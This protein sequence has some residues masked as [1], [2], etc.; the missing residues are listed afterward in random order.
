MVQQY[1][2][3]ALMLEQLRNERYRQAAQGMQQGLN[4]A[5]QTYMNMEQLKQA[6]AE[7]KAERDERARQFN[8]MQKYRD[9][10]LQSLQ[11]LRAGQLGVQQQQ[12]AL[13]EKK[14]GEAR[15]DVLRQQ[16][17]DD[18]KQMALGVE[19]GQKP[20]TGVDT[21]TAKEFMQQGVSRFGQK[22]QTIDEATARASALFQNLEQLVGE[23]EQ[24]PEA[25]ALA[26]A[27]RVKG[28]DLPYG[29]L[30]G[31]MA[32]VLTDRDKAALGLDKLRAE[33]AATKALE[34]QR[35]AAA[36]GG[37]RGRSA[38]ESRAQRN[39]LAEKTVD[40]LKGERQ[41]EIGYAESLQKQA[42]EIGKQILQMENPPLP[43]YPGAPTPV[44]D[45]NRI[46]QLK[47]EQANLLQDARAILDDRRKE[48]QI[49]QLIAG[50]ID[51]LTIQKQIE[52]AQPTD[53]G[54]P[55][56]LRRPEPGQTAADQYAAQQRAI[57]SG[58]MGSKDDL[59]QQVREAMQD[60]ERVTP[61]QLNDWLNM[62]DAKGVWGSSELSAAQERMKELRAEGLGKDEIAAI[63]GREF[64]KQPG[65]MQQ[66]KTNPYGRALLDLLPKP[67]K[68]DY[69][70][71]MTM[72][73]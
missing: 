20:I 56:S 8:E 52:A 54:V 4:Q 41:K 28:V 64:I 59:R 29:E 18:V 66:I 68:T 72:A 31:V 37:G 1:L 2:P 47:T 27:A 48:A 58:I 11:E 33:I 36:R 53:V 42:N 25:L 38:G 69:G 5:L 73:E 63:V 21:Q 7:K 23:Q 14:A 49:N 3:P 13:A 67:P 51:P 65:I 26:E 40:Y 10:Q 24:R 34:T 62:Q 50:T 57:P 45:R 22:A 19:K 35:K 55:E 12:Q 30:R 9:A 43:E 39:Y 60:R 44:I 71:G 46:A 70:T 6:A 16:T 15:A 17:L 32:E 61:E